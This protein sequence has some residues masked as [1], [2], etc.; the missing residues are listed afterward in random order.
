MAVDIASLCSC[1]GEET[2]TLRA[3]LD[4]LD[5]SGWNTATPAEGWSI[6]DQVGHLAFFDT[7][8]TTAVT[9]PDR[10]IADRNDAMK[11]VERFIDTVAA[12]NRSRSGADTYARFTSARAAMVAA[13]ETADPSQRVPWYGP[14][15]SLASAVTARIMET[16]AHGQDIFDALAV[17]HPVTPALRQ[18]AHIG[19]RALPN[20]F[21]TRSLDV[22]TD[23]VR[24][25]LAAPDGEVWTWG[26]DDA[27]NRVEGPAEDFCLVVTQRR[28][29]DDTR[30]VATGDVAQQ[31]LMI[32]QAFAGPPGPGR[33]PGQFPRPC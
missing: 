16:W 27:T 2:A 25:E 15:M 13:F 29:L 9:D 12:A 23:P 22:P 24:V 4:G 7:A 6:K 28:H 10:F 14:E 33:H 3:T 17:P 31:W 20:S 26:P 30:L 8:V 5:E 21:V 18:V 19:V 1:L 32:A 11:G